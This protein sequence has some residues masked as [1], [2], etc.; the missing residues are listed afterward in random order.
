MLYLINEHGV[1]TNPS[2]FIIF[3]NGKTKLSVY[4]AKIGEDYVSSNDYQF[5]PFEGGGSL[6][7]RTST[8]FKTEKEAF[9]NQIDLLIRRIEK[10]DKN[11]HVAL[12]S[13]HEAC[14]VYFPSEV[15]LSLF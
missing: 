4:T 11:N 3:S 2:T 8:T 15:Q 12:K 14:E 6:P 7:S 1:V 5:V 10:S 9:K 13:L